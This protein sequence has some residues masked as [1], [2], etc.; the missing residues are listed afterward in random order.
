[1]HTQSGHGW[2]VSE[3]NIFLLILLFRI[4][5][6]LSV[7]SFFNPDEYWQS[8]EVAHYDVF[9]YGYKTWEWSPEWKV[10]SYSYPA[11]ISLMYYILKI[12]HID[13]TYFLI[14][15]P[16]LLHAVGTATTDWM[17]YQCSIK[18][19]GSNPASFAVCCSLS[20]VN[21]FIINSFIFFLFPFKG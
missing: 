7:Q 4:V 11:I 19:F 1:M 15:G 3:N 5:N 12:L 14:N 10:R 20:I 13:T 2:Q 16:K 21:Q 8:L 9:G 18:W 17:V 6:A